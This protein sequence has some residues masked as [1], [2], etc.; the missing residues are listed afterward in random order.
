MDLPVLSDRIQ[1]EW[2]G[3]AWIVTITTSE[4][5]SLRFVRRKGR[6]CWRH[7]P[8]ISGSGVASRMFTY[9]DCPP[10]EHIDIMER[11]VDSLACVLD[12]ATDAIMDAR[13]TRKA[14]D[15]APSEDHLR[16]SFVNQMIDDQMK[17]RENNTRKTFV[18]LMRHGNG[19]VKIG[20]SSA[21]KVR[22]R[23]LQAE[24]PRLEMISCHLVGDSIEK[25]LHDIFHSVRK[26]GEWFDLEQHH[27]DWIVSVLKSI[28]ATNA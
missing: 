24:D 1:Y 18:Y 25:R 6:W 5:V 14:P 23:T 15:V 26:R 20:R 16:M 10:Q 8:Y 17:A 7:G 12:A 19:L 27:V 2:S 3:I 9:T 22:E 21:P 28:E 13:N 4:G 11:H